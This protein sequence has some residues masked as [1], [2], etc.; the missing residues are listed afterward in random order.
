MIHEAEGRVLFSTL[1]SHLTSLDVGK[2]YTFRLARM[3]SV[4]V[5]KNKKVDYTADRV[6]ISEASDWT[7]IQNMRSRTAGGY[8]LECQRK[9][10]AKVSERSADTFAVLRLETKRD[11]SQRL[12]RGTIDNGFVRKS[13]CAD[14]SNKDIWGS[15]S[16][17]TKRIDVVLITAPKKIAGRAWWL[18][19][20]HPK[21]VN[22]TFRYSD[23]F[24][25]LD[26]LTAP[27]SIC[28][29]EGH[30]ATKEF[31]AFCEHTSEPLK[32]GRPTRASRDVRR[33][34]QNPEMVSARMIGDI[35]E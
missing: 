35:P 6:S 16:P 17:R 4:D 9:G 2:A 26:E 11:A 1:P 3:C 29:P 33:S 23:L 14:K 25:P 27:T 18:T 19:R 34:L 20:C 12:I 13:E 8:T 10:A 32:T 22:M 15:K 31:A 24:E 28:A 21:T 5:K 30:A 7:T